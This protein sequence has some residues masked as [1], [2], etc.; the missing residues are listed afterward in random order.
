M[1][2]VIS[3]KNDKHKEGWVKICDF[4]ISGQLEYHL[5]DMTDGLPVLAYLHKGLDLA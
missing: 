1:L 4:G 3:T 5:G 2:E